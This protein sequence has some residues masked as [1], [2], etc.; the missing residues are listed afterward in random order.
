MKSKFIWLNG[1]FIAW[2][3]AKIH[4]LN[5]SLH[6]GSGVFEGIRFY[7]S[8][9]GP[10]IFRLDDHLKRFFFSA[11]TMGMK[12]DFTPAKLKSEIIELVRKNKL[13]SGYIR[14]IAFYGGK[15]GLD[16]RGAEVN[17]AMACWEWGKYLEKDVVKAKTSS[18]CRIHPNSSRM[19]A[20]ITGHYSN[21][22]LASLEAKGTGFDEALLL[23]YA[24]NIA[25]GPGE[26]IFFVKGSKIYTPTINSI[27]PGLTRDAIIKLARERGYS[28]IEKNIKPKE[29]KKMDEAFFTGTAVE[30]SAIG[31]IDKTVIGKK[32]IGKVTQELQRAYGELVSGQIKKYNKWLTYV[33]K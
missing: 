18:F 14:P 28:V 21:S 10:V 23:D 33:K 26:N 3:K 22:I 30:V 1:K 16:P 11:K 13:S 17:V 8:Q 12:I 24:G 29:I 25:E 27:L 19:G 5:H 9:N 4:V 6:Y 15:M 20:K 32:K 2:D 7:T 31:M